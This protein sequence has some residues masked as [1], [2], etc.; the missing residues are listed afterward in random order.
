M[1]KFL[2]KLPFRIIAAPVWLVL[3]FWGLP[4]R[5]HGGRPDT[6]GSRQESPRAAAPLSCTVY[7]KKAEPSETSEDAHILSRNSS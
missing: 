5:R 1:L 3:A 6:S 2:I 4:A 7:K